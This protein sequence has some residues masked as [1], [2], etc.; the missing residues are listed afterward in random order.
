MTK[1]VLKGFIFIPNEKK[2]QIL[3]ALDEHIKLTK[4]EQG[5]LVFD[6]RLDN[7]CQNKYWIYEKFV[8]KAAFEYH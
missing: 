5:C 8:N 4:Q 1:V 7:E 2:V 3:S 6:I